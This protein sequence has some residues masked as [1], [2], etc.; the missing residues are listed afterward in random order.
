METSRPLER[1]R[2]WSILEDSKAPRLSPFQIEVY[3]SRLANVDGDASVYSTVGAESLDTFSAL[4]VCGLSLRF[5]NER[6]RA[7]HV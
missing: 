3:L 6:E 5:H 4:L 1:A 2:T 7:M